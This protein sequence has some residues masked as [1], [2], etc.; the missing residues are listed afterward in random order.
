MS[1]R[2]K[3]KCLI[4]PSAAWLFMTWSPIS[5]ASSLLRPP[6]HAGLWLTDHFCFWNVPWPVWPQDWEHVGASARNTL[7]HPLSLHPVPETCLLY[8]GSFNCSQQMDIFMMPPP[9]ADWAWRFWG[10]ITLWP[11]SRWERTRHQLTRPDPVWTARVHQLFN[12]LSNFT[13]THSAMGKK[14]LTHAPT[15]M[16]LKYI[17]LKEKS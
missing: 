9:A 4:M 17:I 15:L 2:I 6:V 7:P 5:P 8:G 1:L 14:L 16:N 12:S 10:T 11:H 13:A 3:V